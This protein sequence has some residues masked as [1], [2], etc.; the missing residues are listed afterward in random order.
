MPPEIDPYLAP[1]PD[2][3]RDAL[4]DP[5]VKGFLDKIGKSEGADYNTLVGGRKINDLSRHPNIVGLT[6]SAGPSTAFGKF[7]ITGTTNR[8]KLAKYSHLDYSPENQ[9]LRAVELLRQTKALNAL[10]SGDEPTAMRRAGREWASIP[11]SPLLG[12]KNYAAFA[13]SLTRQDKQDPYLAPLPQTKT[14]DTSLSPQEEQRFKAWKQEYA[15]NDSGADYDLRGAFKSGLKP[16]AK[17][18]HWPDTFKKPNHPT[19]SNES[20]YAVG[21]DVA[22]AGH[23][24][25]DRY[26]PAQVQTSPDKSALA[27]TDDPYLAPLPTETQPTSARGMGMARATSVP[28]RRFRDSAVKPLVVKPTGTAS[29]FGNAPAQVQP[30]RA[31][32]IFNRDAV[33]PISR[34]IAENTVRAG[35]DAARAGSTAGALKSIT[36]LT[37]SPTQLLPDDAQNWINEAVAK[38]GAQLMTTAAGLVRHGIPALEVAKLFG[39]PDVLQKPV[40]DKLLTASNEISQDTR[41]M[42]R[43]VRRGRLSQATQDVVGGTIGSAPAMALISLGIPAPVAFGMQSNAEAQ[44]RD[45]ELS[46][47]IKET[48]KGVA[49]GALFELP[50]PSKVALAGQ[51]GERLSKAALVGTGTKAID[52]ASGADPNDNTSAIVNALFAFSGGPGGGNEAQ[53][54]REAIQEVTPVGSGAPREAQGVQQPNA[55]QSAIP[56][57]GSRTAD[58]G[59]DL[60][61]A[62]EPIAP[63]ENVSEPIRPVAERGISEAQRVRSGSDQD[64]SVVSPRLQGT[65]NVRDNAQQDSGVGL[66]V[67][68][69]RVGSENRAS[70]GRDSTT[71]DLLPAEKGAPQNRTATEAE[72][73]RHVDLQSRFVKGEKSGQF[74]KETRA[75]SEDRRAKVEQASQ[76]IAEAKPTLDLSEVET[77][78]ANRVRE[79]GEIPSAEYTD[80]GMRRVLGSEGGS[81]QSLVDVGVINKTADGRYT[82]NDAIIEKATPKTIESQPASESSALAPPATSQPPSVSPVEGVTAPSI[83]ETTGGLSGAVIEAGRAED[84][85][86]ESLLG[87]IHDHNVSAGFGASKRAFVRQISQELKMLSPEEKV[88]VARIRDGI[89][90]GFAAD[91]QGRSAVGEQLLYRLRNKALKRLGKEISFALPREASTLRPSPAELKIAADKVGVS[92]KVAR[93][94]LDQ[95]GHGGALTEPPQPTKLLQPET[96]KEGMRSFP[97]TLES[98]G[99][100]GGTGRVYDIV[101][102][103]EAIA[104]ADKRIVDD[105]EAARRF[106]LG[107]E[108]SKGKE[109]IATGLRLADQLASE[110]ETSK[111]P[112][113]SASKHAQA[114]ELYT[115]LSTDLTEA[116]Q[117][118]QAASL[119]GKYSATGAPLEVVRIAKRNREIPKPKDISAVREMAKR[120]DDLETRLADVQ[121]QIEDLQAKA[122][123]TKSIPKSRVKI[124]TLSARLT[125]METEARARL[126]SRAALAKSQIVGPKGE[127]GSAVN[128]VDVAASL[129]DWTAIGAAKIARGGINYAT[130]AKEM[131]TEFGDAIRPH[132]EKIFVASR[133]LRDEQ[134]AS[135]K[136]ESAMRRAAKTL[137]AQGVPVTEKSVADLRQEKYDIQVQKR[138]NKLD[139]DRKFKALDRSQSRTVFGKTAGV[140]STMLRDGLLSFHGLANILSGMSVKQAIDTVGRI[141][142]SSLDIARVRGAQMI[143]K[144]VP[145]TAAGLSIK[146]TYEASKYLVTKGAGNVGKALTSKPSDVMP[147]IHSGPLENP[148]V[149][150]LIGPMGRLY[151]AKESLIRSWAYPSERQNQASVLAHNDVLDGVIKRSG[152]NARIDDY[153]TGRT[154]VEGTRN[155][156]YVESMAKNAADYEARNK[157]IIPSAKDMRARE[158]S[159]NPSLLIDSI[160]RQYADRQVYA[161]PSLIAE[162]VKGVERGIRQTSRAAGSATE[163]AQS[164]ALPFVKRPSNAIIDL[165]YTYTGARVPV[166]A[167]RNSFTKLGGE[168]WSPAEVRSF[169]QALARGGAGPTLFA[170]G[171]AL[172]ARGML[173]SQN[174][175]QHP[176]AL[177]IGEKYYAISH[178]PVIGWLMTAGATAKHDGARAV[179]SAIAKMVAEHPLL[180][181]FKQGAEAID[182]GLQ[183][184]KGRTEKIGKAVSSFAGKTVSRFIPTPIAAAAETMDTQ[185]R[186]TRGVLEPSMNRIPLLRLRLPATGPKER[187][188]AFDPF[189]VPPVRLKPRKGAALRF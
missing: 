177:K 185:N 152:L 129:A 38:G 166:E 124:E 162:G 84:Y 143:G 174:D 6:T 79:R 151:G 102:D 19:F 123:P 82:F 50:L 130:W 188:S 77:R 120:Q 70:G 113:E 12:R 107:S 139:M 159:K 127:R 11:G 115:K 16:D 64:S 105:P 109:R 181:T 15:P 147:H 145:R 34:N 83:P 81:L 158:L 40:A 54:N 111:D 164:I 25:G 21:T 137:T 2:P 94:A 61:I 184:A 47:I 100:E 9:D 178:V 1:L 7:Q 13:G 68:Q 92:V 74:K 169:N 45:A 180:R 160:A 97:K 170:L 60:R 76:A 149:N 89:A 20:K 32:E 99:R 90:Q 121:K 22:K 142:E 96:P 5:R 41:A 104:K 183:V 140:A 117:Q 175:K 42:D 78:L 101:G 167:V 135:I 46:E 172:A 114:V 18:G 146:G 189:L 51:L 125:K 163:V 122:K 171:F 75:Q 103:K 43:T 150:A 24:D 55:N 57:A 187:G 179:P 132:L 36:A 85:Q 168:H 53:I 126:E 28:V 26:I 17:T 110:A 59:R 186:D 37:G 108:P 73:Q 88:E 65:V 98:T 4:A 86:V 112:V 35:E 14:Y 136:D 128:P 157:E 87:N 67:P 148:Y 161:N 93:T 144:T 133:K 31:R 156:K 10:M 80:E 141:G 66:R 8:S 33:S 48:T 134:S 63:S 131:I 39:A 153:L 71:Q 3:N 30:T 58:I 118:V 52:L 176:G 62:R 69:E 138:Q 119:A 29:I 155:K 27:E 95:Y 165:L 56:S 173:T 72:S 91:P 49:I 106:A 116:G 23:W 44:G 154:E 182:E